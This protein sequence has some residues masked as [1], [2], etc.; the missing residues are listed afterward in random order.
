MALPSVNAIFFVLNF[1]VMY[2]T[3][4]MA[5]VLW[6]LTAHCAKGHCLLCLFKYIYIYIC[7]CVCVCVC[8]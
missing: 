1:L 4:S 7:V 3:Y 6:L 5:I 2:A 8:V